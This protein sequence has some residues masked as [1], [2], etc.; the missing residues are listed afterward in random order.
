MG[1]FLQEAGW[2]IWPVLFFGATALVAVVGYVRAPGRA[3]GL[4]TALLG[5]LTLV[6]GGLGTATGLQATCVHVAAGAPVDRWQFVIGLRESLNNL[7]AALLLVFLVALVA[8]AAHVR[9][10]WRQQ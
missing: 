8:A 3:R 10:A 4:L 6:A 5:V 2:G 1:T 7:V 9:P